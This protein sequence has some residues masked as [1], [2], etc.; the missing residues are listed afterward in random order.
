MSDLDWERI[1]LMLILI[2]FSIYGWFA[3]KRETERSKHPTHRYN[4]DTGKVERID[5]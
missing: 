3:V 2:G 1:G 5:D 4:R